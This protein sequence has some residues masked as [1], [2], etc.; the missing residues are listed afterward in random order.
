MRA[1]EL[2]LLMLMPVVLYITAGS[3]AQNTK[4]K[5]SSAKPVKQKREASKPNPSDSQDAKSF[6][7]LF[8]SEDF[9]VNDIINSSRRHK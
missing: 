5:S 2:I 8:M 6:D 7:P 3:S 4:Q 1:V 9:D